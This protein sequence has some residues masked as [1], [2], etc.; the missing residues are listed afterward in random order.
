MTNSPYYSSII[1]MKNGKVLITSDMKSEI[2]DPA[3]ETFTPAADLLSSVERS[4]MINLENGEVFILGW[5]YP[6]FDNIYQVYNPASDKWRRAADFDPAILQG[7]RHHSVN[8]LQNGQILFT[9]GYAINFATH[10]AFLMDEQMLGTGEVK[11]EGPDLSLFPNPVTEQ[12]VLQGNLKF[13][14]KAEIKI[15]DV[16]GREVFNV[17]VNAGVINETISVKDLKKGI[18]ILRLVSID[19]VYNKRL[20]VQ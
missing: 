7:L 13:S 15:Y 5:G 6:T 11:N 1:L 4:P 18:Y 16:N 20:L 17:Q 9:G 10:H 8:R 3:T 12:F 14:G 2:Y 19:H